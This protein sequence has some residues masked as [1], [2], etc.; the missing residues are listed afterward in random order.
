MDMALLDRLMPALMQGLTMTMKIFVIAIIAGFILGLVVALMRLSKIW[1]V[2]SIASVYVTV[3]RGTP[4]IVQ[5]FFIY[6]GINSLDAIS[7]DNVT[8]GILTLTL[9][10]GAYFAEIIRAGILAVDKGQVEAARS[11][12]M[13]KT[14]TMT[15][16]VIPQALRRM[17]PTITNQSIISLKDTSLLSII[18]IADITQRGDV[19]ASATFQS[20]E[21]WTI[22]GCVYLVIIWILTLIGSYI[23]RK[24]Q[25]K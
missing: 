1:I 20:F 11:L 17:V 22:V 19:V 5:L 13:S 10:A 3:I 16:I 18:G 12:G 14:K 4:M 7:L 23:E 2:K 9:N 8:A 6:F 24:Y 15:L 25:I 21:V